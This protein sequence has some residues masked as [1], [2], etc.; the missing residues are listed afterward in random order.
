MNHIEDIKLE[1]RGER[2]LIEG[3]YS[4]YTINIREMPVRKRGLS[5]MECGRKGVTERGAII[6]LITAPLV[7]API[8][9]FSIG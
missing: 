5:F 2:E 9:R 7:T 1:G 4:Q 3:L 6:Q 8:L